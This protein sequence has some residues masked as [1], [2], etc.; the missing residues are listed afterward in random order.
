VVGIAD[1]DTITVLDDAKTQHRIRLAGIDA[2]EKGQA[3]GHTSRQHLAELVAGQRVSVEWNKRDR[4][5]RIVGKVLRDGADVCSQ[6]VRA[7]LA[8]WFRKY[9]HEQSPEDRRVYAEAEDQARAGKVGLWRDA[10]PVP[11]W[12]YRAAMRGN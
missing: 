3:F 4:F 10:R 2:P 7:G 11:P 9:Q 5:G 1:G 8:W 12:T 6:Q